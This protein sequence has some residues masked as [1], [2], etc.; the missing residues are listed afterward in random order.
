[1]KEDPRMTPKPV[2]PGEM[3]DVEEMDRARRE[4]DDDLAEM[5]QDEFDA[6]VESM[7]EAA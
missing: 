5:A 7:E 1:M 4:M 6:W 3:F 2:L